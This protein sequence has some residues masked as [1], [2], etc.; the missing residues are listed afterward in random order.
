MLLPVHCPF[1]A[2]LCL[3][4]LF[5]A[6]HFA[7]AFFVAAPCAAVM[8]AAAYLPVACFLAVS[9]CCRSLLL[10]PFAAALCLVA[11]TEQ[12]CLRHSTDFTSTWTQMATE[13][14]QKQVAPS[15]DSLLDSLCIDF[16]FSVRI[17]RLLGRC[18]HDI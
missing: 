11:G 2:D 5:V 8:V 6:A 13:R 15:S 4:A 14:F 3:S 18:K 1:A 9:S 12:M 7:A 17:C 10:S 16:A